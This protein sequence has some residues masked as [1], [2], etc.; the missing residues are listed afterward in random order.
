MTEG[1]GPKTYSPPDDRGRRIRDR[2][3]GRI[4][5]RGLEIGAFT[6]PTRL[7]AAVARATYVD[8]VDLET[9]R[10]V[11]PEYAD[12]RLVTPDILV[13]GETLEGIGDA[14]Q[15][16]VISSHVLEHM[17]DPLGALSEWHRVLVPG[18]GL[19]L[20]IPDMRFTRDCSRPRTTLAHL[21]QDREDG[22]RGSREAHI[23]EF[24]RAHHDLTEEKELRDFVNLVNEN[25]YKVHFHAWIPDDVLEAVRYTETHMGLRW[26]LDEMVEVDYEAILLLRRS[27]E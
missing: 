21:I 2:L 26:E 15:D 12:Q 25:D 6:R 4:R 16:F 10:R 7:H 20:A 9:V 17:E 11:S 1:D 18:G 5:G 14:S 24:G 13:P 27:A 23:A 8:C 22:G 3:A 19:F